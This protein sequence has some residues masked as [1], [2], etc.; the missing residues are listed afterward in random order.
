MVW[1]QIYSVSLTIKC[2]GSTK[3]VLVKNDVL[4]LVPTRK[5]LEL[6]FPKYLLLKLDEVWKF[7]FIS[8]AILKRLREMTRNLCTH[9]AWLSNPTI[10]R[11]CHPPYIVIIPHNFKIL[12]FLPRLSHPTIWKFYQHCTW[13]FFGLVISLV[14]FLF[15]FFFLRFAE[16][17]CKLLC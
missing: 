7:C 15:F 4:L 11:F 6:V 12:L 13:S 1:Q 16:I 2:L 3:V 9:P 17:L 10:S 8:N 14:L 5:I